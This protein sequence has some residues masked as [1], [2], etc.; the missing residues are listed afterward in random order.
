MPDIF[1]DF[2][3]VAKRGAVFE[4][5]TTPRGLDEWWTKTSSGERDAGAFPTR[6]LAV[7]QRSL[8]NFVLLLG[9]VPAHP[10][11]LPRARRARPVRE[12]LDV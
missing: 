12:R 4:A 9:C 11:S 5:I 7:D 10:S 1:H 8:S 2:T 6:R 3:I